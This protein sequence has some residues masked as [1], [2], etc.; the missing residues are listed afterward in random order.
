V[1]LFRGDSA[2]LGIRAMKFHFDELMI[3][4]R[5]LYLL[6][7]PRVNTA[8]TNLDHGLEVMAKRSEVAALGTVHSGRAARNHAGLFIVVRHRGG[9]GVAARESAC[10]PAFA[11]QGKGALC[12]LRRGIRG[13]FH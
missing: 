9:R 2:L 13:F 11:L 6:Q 4:K 7:Q 8:R 10:K 12:Y 5:T 3:Q 1:N